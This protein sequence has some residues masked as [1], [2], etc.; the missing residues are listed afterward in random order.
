MTIRAFGKRKV[1]VSFF[2]LL[3]LLAIR[4]NLK[5]KKKSVKIF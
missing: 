5:L 2:F 1:I 4:G 3:L